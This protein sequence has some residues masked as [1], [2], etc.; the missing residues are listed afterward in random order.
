VHNVAETIGL[1]CPIDCLKTVLSATAF[2]LLARAYDAPF[3]PPSTV[4]EVVEL[5]E[6]GQLRSISGLGPRRVGEIEVALIFA[7]VMRS[8]P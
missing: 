3:D 1:D 4:G 5:C 6:Q 2:S 7:G 8:W